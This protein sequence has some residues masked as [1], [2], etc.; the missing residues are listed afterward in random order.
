[1]PTTRPP[2]RPG[3]PIPRPRSLPAVVRS[4]PEREDE[5]RAARRRGELLRLRRGVYVAAGPHAEVPASVALERE[6]QHLTH[7]AAVLESLTTDLW[8]S[9][10]SAALL[11]GCWTYGLRPEA[12]ITQL[13]PPDVRASAG[14]VRRHWTAL[15]MRDRTTLAGVPVTTLERT[16]VDCA[17]TLPGEQA[18]VVADSAS[19]IGI[20][21]SLV[22]RIL[23]ES[24]G[25]RGVRSARRV[26]AIADGAVES[27]GEARLRWVLGEAG[28]PPLSAAIAVST[29]AGQRWVDLGWQ[30][31]KVG[32]E[33][34]G[35]LKYRGT[36]DEVESAL[37]EEKRRH[38]ALVEA[39]WILLRVSWEDLDNLDGLVARVLAAR[40]RAAA[41]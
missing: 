36:T 16:V 19:R 32:L 29:W 17:L 18:V 35:R 26:L 34:D 2:S 13:R 41:R 10:T 31:L 5:I 38:D 20:D 3:S 22:R 28:L 27:P 37:Y 14:P 12:E 39:G 11:W 24:L 33:F 40:G 4:T 30:D 6:R 7:L 21:R 9:H 1:M 15:P 23:A 25:K 8:V